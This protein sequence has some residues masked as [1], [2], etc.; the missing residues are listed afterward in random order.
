MCVAS[1]VGDFYRDKWTY[2]PPV[3]PL[4]E[5]SY[6]GFHFPAYPTKAEFDELRKEVLDMKELLKRAVKYDAANNEPHCE[7]AEKLKVLRKVAALVGVSLDDVLSPE[8]S[9]GSPP[10]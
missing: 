2:Q 1:M 5:P 7:T 6:T 3:Q 4:I 9:P 10:A 8:P